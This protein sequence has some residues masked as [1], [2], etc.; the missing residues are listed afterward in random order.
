MPPALGAARRR[1]A[2]ARVAM[3]LLLTLRGTPTLYHGDELAMENVA[4][5]PERQ[6]DP[7]GLNMPG[8]GEGR[9][10]ERTPMPWDGSANGGFTAGEP[11][12]PLGEDNARRNVEAQKSTPGSMLSLTRALLEM[13]R[14]EP[15]LC[16]GDWAPL[17]LEGDVLAY[18]RSRDGRCFVVVLNLTHEPKAIRFREDLTGQVVF[19]THPGRIDQRIQERA[20]LESDEAQIIALENRG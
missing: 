1:Q 18:R 2:Q 14:R 17:A 10:P 20:Q 15:A 12:L 13:R 5:P 6:L 8:T 9:D 19:A 11:W 4:I 7:F 16:L 3:V